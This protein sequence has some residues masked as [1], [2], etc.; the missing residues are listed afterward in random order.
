MSKF[1]DT[2]QIY[3]HKNS[4][5][6]SRNGVVDI[7][8]LCHALRICSMWAVSRWKSECYLSMSKFALRDF[9]SS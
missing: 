8:G 5:C 7:N 6:S 4:N 2:K 1:Q 9:S 3:F